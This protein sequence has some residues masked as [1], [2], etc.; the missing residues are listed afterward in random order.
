MNVNT[1]NPGI[2]RAIAWNI[3][4]FLILGTAFLPAQ[5]DDWRTD[6]DWP[7]YS[8]DYSNTNT[9]DAEKKLNRITAKHLVRAWETF[10]DDR[11]VSEP[12]PTG[13]V[14]ESALG[15]TYPSAVVGVV[16]PP[17]VIDGTIYYVDEL[18]TV[19]SRDAKT[20]KRR[21][22]RKHW[23]TT[24]ADPDYAAGNPPVLPELFYTAPTV[25][26]THI[27]LAGSVYGQLHAIER[28][29]GA[30]VDFDPTTPEIDPYSLIPDL[31]FSSILAD[32]VIVHTESEYGD[33]VL[34]ITGVNVILDDALV[35]GKEAGIQV[36]VDITDPH[37]PFEA[38]RTFTVDIDPATGLRY[39]TGVSAGAG[40]AVDA[41][42]NLVLGGTGQNTSVPYPGYP[43]PM[44]APPGYVDR[45]DSLYAIDYRTG[46]Y[47]WT[48]QF[49]TGDVFDLN[50]PVSTGPGNP[51]GLHD[52]DVLSPPV[53]W[54]AIV[55]GEMLDLAGVG[56]KGGLY[57]VA[58]R[59]TGATV[60]E[61]Q[62][63]KPTG[64]GGIQAGSAY[65][66]DTVYVVGFE[67]ID[68][69]FSDAQFGISLDTGIFPNAFFATFSPAFWADVE[70]TGADNDPATGMRAKVYALDAATG[71]SRW[72]FGDGV[73]FVELDA[74]AALRHVS[75]ANGLIF[76]TTTSGT[77]F[78]LDQSGAIIYS[79]QSVDLNAELQ[80]GLGKPHHASMNAGTV[81]SDGMVFVGYGAQ[82][83]PSGGMLAYKIDVVPASLE[84]LS[85]LHDDVL[86]I[87]IERSGLEKILLHAIT[88]ITGDVER[89]RFDK[90]VRRLE[91]L[92]RVLRFASAARF[93][94]PQDADSLISDANAIV[95]LRDS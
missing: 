79:D 56:S 70:D 51:D 87:G 43:D 64:I 24:L 44:L 45:S 48:N 27:W 66:D 13:F 12:R 29:G 40:L 1:I 6:N 4:A 15:L 90:A 35:Q 18:G 14:L 3:P 26:D 7:L 16:A 10:N 57:R 59:D 91:L 77:L 78:V 9:N 31:P 47:R 61:R 17:I 85:I 23:T 22:R 11:W 19:F 73:D 95:V 76:V 82:N 83:N 75:T 69:G 86:A 53:L 34:Y 33:R 37:N 68:D 62:I 50:A 93:L 42:R 28:N 94:S 46:A 5:A 80:L 49:H 36:A 81:I 60:W 30:A 55:D 38:W 8:H 58:D 63:S 71:E 21:Y 89:N 65:A 54:S 20:G 74:G 72:D 67:G 84:L 92:I 32:A 52:A 25:T 41:G 2:L 39:G 88:R